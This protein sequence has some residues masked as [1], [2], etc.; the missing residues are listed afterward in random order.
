MILY[1]GLSFKWALTFGQSYNNIYTE[2]AW[3]ERDKW[4]K[5]ELI[6][7]QLAVSEGDY[8]ADIGCNEGYMTIKLSKEVGDQGKVY[9]V[10]ISSYKLQRL[11]EHLE[12]RKLENINPIEGEPDNPKL[13]ANVLDAVLILDTYHEIGSPLEVLDKVKLSLKKDGRLVIVEPVRVSLRGK[14]R[15]EQTGKHEIDMHFVKEDLEKA[16]FK[17]IKEQDPFIDRTKPKGDEL[18]LLVAIPN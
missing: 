5:P 8:V 10:D 13:P 15:S 2:S 1:L 17:I 11:R 7:K 9:A 18:W 16:G 6:I 4:Q 14:G 3:E 12:E